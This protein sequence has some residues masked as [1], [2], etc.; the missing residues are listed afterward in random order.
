MIIALVVIRRH[1][2]ALAVKKSDFRPVRPVMAKLLRIGVPIA[3]QDGLIQ[4]AFIIITVIATA[5]D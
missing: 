3:M 2:G 1:S 4:I 5:G